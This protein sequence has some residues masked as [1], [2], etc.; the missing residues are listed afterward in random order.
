MLVKRVVKYL[1]TQLECVEVP[2][3]LT[4]DYRKFKVPNTSEFFFVTDRMLFIGPKFTNCRPA[5]SVVQ[6]ASQQ[7]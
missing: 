6:H 5:H 3:K 7:N 2:S 1:Q 4:R